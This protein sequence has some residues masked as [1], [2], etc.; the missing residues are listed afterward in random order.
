M[1]KYFQVHDER[2]L[3]VYI[4]LLYS[5]AENFDSE[6]ESDR[7]ILFEKM[8]DI[9]HLADQIDQLF[10]SIG[11]KAPSN[12]NKKEIQEIESIKKNIINSKKQI[13]NRH[14]EI[15]QKMKVINAQLHLPLRL[16]CT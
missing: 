7:T 9:R 8:R 4:D 11:E 3:I 14:E 10:E 2:N 5:M 13:E 6:S 16:F 1:V 12:L 15:D